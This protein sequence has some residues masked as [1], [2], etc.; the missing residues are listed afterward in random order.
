MKIISILASI[1][2]MFTGVAVQAY[3][4]NLIT[5]RSDFHLR[6]IIRMF[7]TNTGI[8]VNAV[9]MSE[10]LLPRLEQRPGEADIVLTNESSILQSAKTKGLL[11]PHS[12]NI[13]ET[14]DNRFID[15]D[16][17]WVAISYR[18]RVLYYN[19]N[20]VDIRELSTYEDMADPK[21]KGRICIRSGYHNYNL[22][23]F[24]SMLEKHGELFT[25]QWLTGLKNNLAQRPQGN[26]R[27]Q[28]KAINAG[29]CDIAFVNTY[30][31]GVMLE[32]PAQR[33][34][35]NDVGMY[36]P[37]QQDRGT[38]ILLSSAAITRHAANVGNANKFLSYLLEDS[39]QQWINNTTYEYPVRQDV[40]LSG[41]VL[42]FGSEQSIKGIFTSNSVSLDYVSNHRLAIIQI[43][44]EIGFDR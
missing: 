14:L 26:D 20:K 15:P 37:N 3:E 42:S 11:Q 38:A 21:W 5:D 23:L 16:G 28:V 43:L 40:Q 33:S 34:W 7:E 31:M 19:K 44:D 41:M 2:V 1:V 4:L 9:F 6:P 30:Y 29:I 24:A 13:P 35:T 32:N 17:T 27:S 36:F 22:N 12:A 39:S 10:G 25:R 8:K 18:A